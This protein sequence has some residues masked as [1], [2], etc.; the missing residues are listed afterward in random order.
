[1][2]PHTAENFPDHIKPS[3][4]LSLGLQKMDAM[5]NHLDGSV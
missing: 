5:Y 2:Y 1:M 3:N 4:T